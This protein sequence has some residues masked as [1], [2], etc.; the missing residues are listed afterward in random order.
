MVSFNAWNSFDFNIS[1]YFAYS[2]KAKVNGSC[3]C[4][5]VPE[6]SGE[7]RLGFYNAFCL[8]Y[9]IKNLLNI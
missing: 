3:S 1:H 6:K 2:L 5:Y 9:S 8:V 7:K 4:E